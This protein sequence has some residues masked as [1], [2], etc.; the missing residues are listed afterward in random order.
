MD[1]RISLG[2]FRRDIAVACFETV[3][4]VDEGNGLERNTA[5]VSPLGINRG[6]RETWGN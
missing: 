2:S 1:L 3:D 4:R 5:L 6:N